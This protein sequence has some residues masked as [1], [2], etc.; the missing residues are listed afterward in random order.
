[1]DRMDFT[2]GI[3]RTRVIEKRLLSKDQIDRMIEANDLNDVL[4]IL[5]ETEYSNEISQMSDSFDYESILS[6][7]LIRVYDLMREISADQMVIDL[8]ALKYDYHNL[9]VM[10]KEAE[11]NKE[12]SHLYVPVGATN[13]KVLKNAFQEGNMDLIGKEYREAIVAVQKDYDVTR[14]PQR[15]D[16]IFDRF[17]YEHLYKM[18]KESEIDF[19]IEYVEDVIDFTNVSS[20]IRLKRQGREEASFEDV[21][22][23]GGKLDS[24]SIFQIINEPLKI[25][26]SRISSAL[27][28]GLL[29]YEKTNRL[30]DFEKFKDDYLMGKNKESKSVIF[31]PEPIFSYVLAKEAEIKNLRIIMVSKT[32]N[33]PSDSIR[34]RMR[35][36]Y[37]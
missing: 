24:G 15:I 23:A 33:I 35:D 27:S 31:G 30:T 25:K 2:Q 10:I 11:L 18:A 32:N 34:E 20:A 3:V 16:L 12:L 8:L 37:V 22:L 29:A 7:E 28:K 6:A 21:M 36:L 5:N 14:D 17:Y 1:M 4:R 9:K 19:F 26:D 13:F